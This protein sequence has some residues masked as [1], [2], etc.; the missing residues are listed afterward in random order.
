MRASLRQLLTLEFGGKKLPIS[1]VLGTELIKDKK[2]HL[3][4]LFI[5]NV[6]ETEIYKIWY[7][8]ENILL[9]QK[10][11]WSWCYGWSLQLL[12]V[13]WT[14]LTEWFLH[15]HS[16]HWKYFQ[17]VF[18][19][20]ATGQIKNPPHLPPPYSLLS[21]RAC[22]LSARDTHCFHCTAYTLVEVSTISP[23]PL[24]SLFSHRKTSLIRDAQIP[25]T[26]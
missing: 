14:V 9:E 13:T 4:K 22:W 11:D 10:C 25:H 24:K 7:N 26:R 20:L 3:F 1:N 5:F 23:F 6:I 2:L 19:S 15:T 18:L 8:K 17:Y 12:H 21:C 16:D